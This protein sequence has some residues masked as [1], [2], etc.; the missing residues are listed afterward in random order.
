MKGIKYE[1]FKMTKV[2]DKL[3][4]SGHKNQILRQFFAKKLL[5]MFLT[6]MQNIIQK[7]K[8]LSI[9]KTNLN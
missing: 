1:F 2:K 3:T 7:L 4:K 6:C 5:V 8:N 9:N